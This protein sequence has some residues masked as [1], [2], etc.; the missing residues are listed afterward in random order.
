[1][2]VPSVLNNRVWPSG[3]ALVTATV[4]MFVFAPGRFSI[5]TGCFHFSLR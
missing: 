4:P 1:M 2:K 5:T 3:S